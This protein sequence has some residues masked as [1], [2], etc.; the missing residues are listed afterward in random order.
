MRLG[1][2][3]LVLGSAAAGAALVQP[4]PARAQRGTDESILEQALATEESLVIKYDGERFAEAS[5]FAR[6]CRDHLRGLRMALRNRGGRLK[7]NGGSV[8]AAARP[9]DLEDFAVRFYHEAIGELDDTRLLPLFAAIMANHGQHLVVL[10]QRLGRDP[11]PTA[12][13]TGSVQ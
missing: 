4:A 1:R 6:H 7:P 12:F 5:L 13:E 8:A 9:I 2:R 10:R 3:D 11:I